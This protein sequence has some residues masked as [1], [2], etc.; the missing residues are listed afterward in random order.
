MP[1]AHGGG[2]DIGAGDD[3]RQ[4]KIGADCL[5]FEEL[6]FLNRESTQ[7]DKFEQGGGAD[8]C[9]GFVGVFYIWNFDHNSAVASA[10]NL[11]F[12]DTQTVDTVFDDFGGAD[13]LV[14]GDC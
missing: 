10:H 2:D 12:T 13:H 11:G 8:G 4:P 5:P 6:G 7:V 9:Q 1:G 3:A 14:A